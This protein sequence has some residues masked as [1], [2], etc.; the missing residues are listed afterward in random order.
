[1]I[2]LPESIDYEEVPIEKRYRAATRALSARIGALYRR[3][4]DEF[5]DEALELIRSVN[6]R[7][8][9]DLARDLCEGGGPRDAGAAALC[10][11]RLL[12]LVGMDGEVLELSPACARISV[13]SCPFGISSPELCEARTT[14]ESEFVRSLADDLHVEIEKCA[15]LGDESCQF[16]IDRVSR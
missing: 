2:R 12:D 14:L 6:R 15:A 1:M 3:A 13:E 10:L 5:G 9:R 16:R 8:A 11:A 4:V 7:H